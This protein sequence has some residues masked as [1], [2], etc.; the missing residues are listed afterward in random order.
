MAGSVV[1]DEQGTLLSLAAKCRRGAGCQALEANFHLAFVILKNYPFAA[2]NGGHFLK[3]AFSQKQ[4]SCVEEAPAVVL[5]QVCRSS[6]SE[7]GVVWRQWRGGDCGPTWRK[8]AHL[9]PA[10]AR[11]Q[12]Q[13]M[14]GVQ[15]CADS[16]EWQLV[17]LV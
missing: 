7:T 8:G 1:T 16:Q 17:P 5:V 4:S 15:T 14:R 3:D 9:P 2:Q 13:T 12:Q 11:E 6:G 10:W